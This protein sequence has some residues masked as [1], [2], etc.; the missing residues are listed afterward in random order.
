MKSHG[1]KEFAWRGRC[2]EGGGHLAP[3][4]AATLPYD[5]DRRSLEAR[6]RAGIAFK[7]PAATLAYHGQLFGWLVDTCI[8]GD[9]E[10]MQLKL[11]LHHSI[12]LCGSDL[13]AVI[14]GTRATISRDVAVLARHTWQSC[15]TP[16]T[17]AGSEKS[18]EAL[19]DSKA[20]ALIAP[21]NANRAQSW[22]RLHRMSIALAW[23]S[24]CKSCM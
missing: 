20:E 19:L 9:L 1:E 2:E 14:D 15:P 8:I 16:T 23:Y 6:D 10:S 3:E 11:A 21:C 5:L 4:R 12:W 24:A 13:N 18:D 7:L 17:F 22:K